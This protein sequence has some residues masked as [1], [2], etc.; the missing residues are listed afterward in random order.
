MNITTKRRKKMFLSRDSNF[1]REGGIPL[2]DDDVIKEL[3][4]L[5]K[6]MK[7]INDTHMATP[8]FPINKQLINSRQR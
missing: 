4:R 2:S 8:A 5:S 6:K 7:K 3:L 1:A